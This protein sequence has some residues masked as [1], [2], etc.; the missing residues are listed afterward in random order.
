MKYCVAIKEQ[1]ES[2]NFPEGKQIG[3]FLQIPRTHFSYLIWLTICGKSIIYAIFI[4]MMHKCTNGLNKKG[5]Q[6]KLFIRI[7]N[8]FSPSLLYFVLLI[9]L[10]T[11][12]TVYLQLYCV[13]II[14]PSTCNFYKYKH[15]YNYR[16]KKFQ[17]MLE[18]KKIMQLFL[19]VVTGL[20]LSME[21][22]MILILLMEFA[23][24]RHS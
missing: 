4:I 19:T 12:N 21:L 9:I 18:R 16:K 20:I 13:L 14:I 8:S 24:I 17:N 2:L 7:S 22:N 1:I 10:C 11:C 23:C 3:M 5:I 15:V 6:N